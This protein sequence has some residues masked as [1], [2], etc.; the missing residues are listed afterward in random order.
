MLSFS[1][2]Y[3]FVQQ[4]YQRARSLWSS[5]RREFRIFRGL[6]VTLVSDLDAEW[7]TKVVMTDACETGHASVEGEWDLSEVQSAGRW[8]ERWRFRHTREADGGWRPR[9]RAARAAE[10]AELDAHP[11]V[12]LRR[13]LANKRFPEVSTRAIRRTSWSTM[14]Y[15]PLFGKEP[16]HRKE[17]RGDLRAVKLILSD[18][19]SWGK[20]RVVLG[21]N[22]AL[23]LALSKGR[24]RDIF[25]LNILRRGAALTLASGAR[26]HRR[27]VP[28]EFNAA[29]G[30]SRS[31]E[32]VAGRAA[33]GASW[34]AAAAR[35]RQLRHRR[36][37][38][39]GPEGD[40]RPDSGWPAAPAAPPGLER[41]PATGSRAPAAVPRPGGAGVGQAAEAQRAWEWP[42]SAGPS[43]ALG[44]SDAATPQ[45][46]PPGLACLAPPRG[47]ASTSVA[48]PCGSYRGLLDAGEQARDTTRQLSITEAAAVGRRSRLQCTRLLELFLRR[49]RLTSLA[50]P[51][52]D[53]GAA[54]VRFFDEL[55]LE[56]KVASTGEKLLAAIFMHVPDYQS[57]GKLALPR[58][59]RALRGWRLLRPSR[60]RRPLPWAAC[61]GVARQIWKISGRPALAVFWL[62][63]VDTYLRPGE[64]FRL[65]C[66]QVIPPQAHVPKVTIHINPDYMKRPS[67]TGEMDETVDVARPWLGNLL[68][69]LAQGPPSGPLWTFTMTEAKDV[70]E[71]A[72]RALHLDKLLPVLYTARHSGV[73]IDRFTGRISLQEVQR[74]GRWRQPSSVRRYEKRGLIQAVWSE[75]EPSA[76]AYCLQAE[77]ELPSLL[78]AASISANA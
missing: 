3:S 27:W 5:A 67:K 60:T 4:N 21:D 26:M 14:Y 75:M 70:F 56:G 12:L 19:D 9:D 43:A 34:R 31:R 42:V 37:S 22:L 1:A 57:K 46:G 68:V 69:R 52:A 44:G 28:S 13:G 61:M 50:A 74:R 15:S 66:G 25:L 51:A 77:A 63:M 71:R 8:H 59:Y 55:Y 30:D 20:R 54:V 35:G 29:D 2:V 7:S 16:M 78:A 48:S 64:A 53:A 23:A 33:S 18:A 32:G 72:T 62:L 40:G 11:S 45:L 38:A 47:S 6:L 73:S 58:A 24:C 65:T 49:S 39:R 36:S 76:K 17:A 10:A 41:C